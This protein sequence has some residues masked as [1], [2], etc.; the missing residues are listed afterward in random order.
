MKEVTKGV[1]EVHLDGRDPTEEPDPA[2]REAAESIVLPESV[3]LPEEQSGELD[4]SD[5]DA[6]PAPSP[7]S[8]PLSPVNGVSEEAEAED[9]DDIASSSEGNAVVTE[10]AKLQQKIDVK[11]LDPPEQT[12]EHTTKD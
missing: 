6:N 9:S 5:S 8:A 11:A 12:I 2:D 7:A 4:Q 1:K 3:P 10:E